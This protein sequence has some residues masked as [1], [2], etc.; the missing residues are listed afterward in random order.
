MGVKRKLVGVGVVHAAVFVYATQSATAATA[1]HL[2]GGGTASI[3]QV[4]FNLSVNGSGG[5]SVRALSRGPWHAGTLA[6]VAQ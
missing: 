2:S 4:A 3:S 5:A 6:R 1:G